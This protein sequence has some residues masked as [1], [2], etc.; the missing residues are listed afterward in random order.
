MP[1]QDDIAKCKGLL[2]LSLP[3]F[4]VMIN[5]WWLEP[6][7]DTYSLRMRFFSLVLETDDDRPDIGIGNK[8]AH[9]WF[10]TSG[11][12]AFLFDG[13][14][15]AAEVV[16]GIALVGCLIDCLG[17]DIFLMTKEL[18]SLFLTPCSNKVS[19]GRE[20]RIT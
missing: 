1:F 13:G 3:F 11:S 5:S 8:A 14:I 20:G 17:F 15:E 19:F 7:L 9:D 12:V 16:E 2:R 4:L 10:C 18:C 6:N